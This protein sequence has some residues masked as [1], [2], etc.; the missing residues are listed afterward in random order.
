MIDSFHLFLKKLSIIKILTDYENKHENIINKYN[1][2]NIEELLL[3]LNLKKL[4]DIL[5][6]NNKNEINFINI[7]KIFPKKIGNLEEMFYSE[8]VK[9]YNYDK[10]YNH[11]INNI[12]NNKNEKYLTSK[13]LIVHFSPIKFNFIN[14]DN[15]I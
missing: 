12:K 3:F 13:E 9:D 14:L 7:I 11:I 10:I 6:K 2:L 15:N 4:N 5:L 8:L 1:E